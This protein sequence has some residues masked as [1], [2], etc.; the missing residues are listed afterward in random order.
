MYNY[1]QDVR[2]YWGH[3]VL[4]QGGV[5]MASTKTLVKRWLV[6]PLVL[7]VLLFLCMVKEVLV[8]LAS[9]VLP[10][11]TNAVVRTPD[12]RFG[13]VGR[14]GYAFEPNYVDLPIGGGVCLPRVHYIDEGPRDAKET[15]L[16]LHGEPSWSFLYRKM[17]PGLLKAGYRV[18]APDFIGF[19]KSDKYTDMEQYTHEMHKMTLRLLLN[20]LKV[21]DV[22]L[23]CQDW[24][25]LV[26]LSVVREMP[27]IFSR[28]VIMNTGLP[29]GTI[30]LGLSFLP[31]L[32][33]RSF[34]RLFGTLLPVYD[35]FGKAFLNPDQA[36]LEAY[37]AP[38]PSREYK[39]GAAQWPL[40]VPIHPYNPVSCDMQA[41]REF[42]A[43]NWKE[44][45]ALI[46]FSDRDPITRG[47]EK[48]F[49]KL[50]PHASTKTV[51]G[52]QHFLQEDKGEELTTHII[53]FIE[54]K[55]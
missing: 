33:W 9:F 35:I 54:G 13:D 5:A 40:L 14:L 32:M 21:G 55:L 7:L 8:E 36:V 52:A 47:Q 10:R 38:F 18:I 28:L 23:V 15:I 49:L 51:V 29:D 45:P 48:M 27:H 42:L 4:L 17:V 3:K 19:G 41:T 39:A 1:L 44:R 43:A 37:A 16:C 11:R 34:A 24:G 12:H 22:T 25:G 6:Y 31:F 30:D 26:G 20:H 2:E 46:M 53:S 50:L